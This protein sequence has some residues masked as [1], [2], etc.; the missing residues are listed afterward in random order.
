MNG[1]DLIDDFVLAE[2]ADKDQI[3]EACII[4]ALANEPALGQTH[5]VEASPE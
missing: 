3:R 2:T 5:P 1:K 4:Q